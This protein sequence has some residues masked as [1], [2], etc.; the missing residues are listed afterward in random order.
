MPPRPRA[1]L[2]AAD[3]A[4]LSGARTKRI[5]E[6]SGLGVLAPAGDGSY[7]DADIH[8]VRAV[9]AFEEAGVP[10]EALVL[11]QAQG[12]VSFA[13]YGELHTPVG[14]PSTRSY[15]AFRESLGPVG[16]SL[17]QLFAAL[18]IA[19]PEPG[20]HRSKEDE[21]FLEELARMVIATGQPDMVLRVVRVYGEAI[22]RA[23]EAALTTYAEVVEQIGPEL[24]GL[25]SPDVYERVFR[26]WS[27]IAR[28][29]PRLAAWLAARHISRAIDAYSVGATE[30]ILE[31]GGFIPQRPEREPAVVFLDLAGF[32]RLTDERGDET[33]A[34]IAFGPRRAC[35]AD[36]R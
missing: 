31:Q 6:L 24:A 20:S 9:H 15:A 36:C 11:A 17:P 5:E 13:Y 1:P 12:A 30:Q 26:P 14:P 32:T 29:A 22:R 2:S 27:R 8:R 18:G 28:E 19:E 3:L 10:L 16:A 23:S 34:R 25:P 7:T 35:G 4:A 21:A 33:A